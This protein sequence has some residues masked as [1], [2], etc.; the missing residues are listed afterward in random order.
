MD[1]ITEAHHK[2]RIAIDK[3]CS[4]L[5][6]PRAT[7]YRHQDNSKNI[8]DKLGKTPPKNALNSQEKQTVIDL[9]HSEQFVDKTPYQL[10]N[11]LID[12]GVYYCSI[13]TMYRILEEKDENFDRRNQRNHR[14]AVK[15][16]LIATRPNGV[17]TAEVMLLQDKSSGNLLTG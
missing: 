10:F 13:R 16:E 7:Y 5:E 6:I 1:V 3:L 14:D 11:N 8:S 4:A 12:Q 2:Y 9:L 17:K 15:P